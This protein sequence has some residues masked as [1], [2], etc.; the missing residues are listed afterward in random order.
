M[1]LGFR[2]RNDHTR[3]APDLVAAF[4]KIP[5]AIISDNLSRMV[6]AGPLV[7]PM[8][9][10]GAPLAGT[11]LTVKTRPGDNL[12][13][14][15]AAHS[16]KHLATPFMGWLHFQPIYDWIIRTDPDLVN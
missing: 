11:A 8:H 12:M 13:I 10:Y 1:P 5:A 15:K 6:S 2:V 14:H 4:S 3:A 16:A 9:R 7:R